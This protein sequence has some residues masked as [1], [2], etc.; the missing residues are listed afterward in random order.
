[1]NQSNAIEASCPWS[2]PRSRANRNL[3]EPWR[4]QEPKM[5]VEFRKIGI[6]I[7]QSSFVKIFIY[8]GSNSFALVSQKL[9]QLLRLLCISI[10]PR[11]LH[12]AQNHTRQ[13]ITKIVAFFD[14]DIQGH[15]YQGIIAH[16]V[17]NLYWISC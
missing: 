12:N 15:N 1:M 8:E 10:T 14:L 7:N 9:V 13:S 17:P 4:K 6:L 11:H 5:F 3:K 16:I 2:K